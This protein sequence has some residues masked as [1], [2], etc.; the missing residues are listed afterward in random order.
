MEEL[1]MKLKEEEMKLIDRLGTL[2]PGSKE[3]ADGVQ[4]LKEV[5]DLLINLNKHKK[6]VD[7]DTVKIGEDVKLKKEQLA[8][9]KK[10]HVFNISSSVITNTVAVLGVVLPLACYGAWL[11]Q[12]YQFEQ[13]GVISSTTTKGLLSKLRPTK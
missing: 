6:D 4:D 2:Q 1:V 8:L 5:N 7:F 3:Y 9:D 11:Q 12:G 13:E 10:K